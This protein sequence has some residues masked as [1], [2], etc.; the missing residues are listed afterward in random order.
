VKCYGT[1][2]K[3]NEELTLQALYD[4]CQGHPVEKVVYMHNKGSFREQAGNTKIRRLSTTAVTS[5]ACLEMPLSDEY[6]CNVCGLTFPVQTLL[7]Y[8]SQFL[9]G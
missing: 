8:D 7:S 1:D 9:D 3:G 5:H 6:P 4:Y 2:P